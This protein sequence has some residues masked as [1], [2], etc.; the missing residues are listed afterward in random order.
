MSHIY[1]FSGDFVKKRL[2]L[3]KT[4]DYLGLA[5]GMVF[6]V[7][8]ALWLPTSLFQKPLSFVITDANGQLLGA[9]VSD[10]GQWR[11][12]PATA[13][14]EKYI[15]SL[16]TFEDKR[17][18]LHPGIDPAGILRA[19]IAN[20]KS[21]TIVS[22]GSTISMQLARMALEHSHRNILA[23]ITEVFYAL[24]IEL[25]Y[26]KNEI[27]QIYASN[28]P[29]G[30]NIVGIEAAA[31]K[32]FNRNHMHLSWAEAALLAI[33][34][35]NPA[36]LHPGKNRERLL[37]RRNAL[38]RKMHAQGYF[39]ET[40]LEVSLAEPLPQ[41][42]LALPM[43]ATHA[44]QKLFIEKKLERNAILPTTIQFNLQKSINELLLVHQNRLKANHIYNLAV[45]VTSVETGQVL[46]YAANFNLESDQIYQAHVDLI[47]A[48]R[49]TG[50]ILKPFLYAALLTGGDI[51][52][53]SLVPDI[54]I[55]YDGFSPQNFNLGYD[56]AVPAHRALAR[57]LNVPAVYLLKNF[58]VEKFHKTLKD[59]GL[60][61]ITRSAGHYGLSLVLG[62]AEGKLWD[63][64]AAYAGMAR[65]LNHYQTYLGKYS[66][67]DWHPNTFSTDILPTEIKSFKQQEY[68]F[69]A[70]A[71][72]ETFDAMLDVERP[73]DEQMWQRLGAGRKIAWKTGTSFGF[74]DAWAI[75]VTPEYIVGVWAGN[76]D[77]TGRPGL[78]GIQSAAPVLFDVYKLLP[79][80]TWFLKPEADMEK[81]V[82]CHESGFLASSNCENTDTVYVPHACTK[83]AV[84]KYHKII[85]LSAD[86]KFQ[87]HSNCESTANMVH[88]KWFVL[89]PVM[90]WYYKS[91][92]ASYKPL[93]PYRADCQ[94]TIGE[95]QTRS[96][97]IIYPKHLTSIYLPLD[98]NNR[99]Q[100]AVFEVAH[101]NSECNIYWYVDDKFAGNTFGY[102]R[103]EIDAAPGTHTLTLTDEYGENLKIIFTILEK[104]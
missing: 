17:F 64:S 59:I 4:S 90:E 99:K 41:K 76:A 54:P 85:H 83:S 20:I 96:M 60:T 53:Q 55:R 18:Y 26:S 57:S 12:P 65:T 19:A 24:R 98:I 16:I 72:F 81:V 2:R 77:G 31:W 34:P 14:S 94:R 29:F 15:L 69:S 56:G 42:P 6:Y 25:S 22:G 23:K 49:S 88:K 86:E 35:N 52:P 21:R 50:S 46:A 13:L 10:D 8:F 66:P 30:G 3:R 47:Q 78:T 71:I 45:I 11:F 48:Q 36:G 79:H 100:Q 102:H 32:Y 92:N 82:L 87:V 95:N 75:G 91:A 89:P 44:M 51:T 70:S 9:K 27:L 1:K 43:I 73:E 104:L 40:T 93:P 37:E 58:G 38:L 67:N 74:R 80:T 63:L 103:L 62:G 61:T 39:D 7:A 5:W 68:I 97:Q 33:L 84:C 101:R 28:A